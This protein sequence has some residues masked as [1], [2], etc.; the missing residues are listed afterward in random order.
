MLKRSRAV[1]ARRPLVV[2][3]GLLALVLFGRPAAGQTLPTGF[4]ESIVFSGLTE[5]TALQFAPD[6]RVF[7]A[8]KSGLVKVFDG[9]SDTTATVF[10]DLRT[11]VHNFWDR[12][13]LGLALHPDFPTTPYV[14][15]LYAYDAAIGGTA[16]RWGTVGATSDPCPDPPGATTDGCVVSG[17]LSRLQASGNVMTGSE[18]VLI[19]DWCQQYPSHSMG[20]LAFGAD[21]ALYVSGGDGSSFDFVDYGQDGNPLNP[22]GDPPVGVG[23]VQS[24]P[25]AEGGS[26]RTQSLR[27]VNGPVVLG[28]TILR[29]DP[30]TGAALP[31]NPLADHPDS[32]A[33]RVIAYGLRNPFRFTPRPGTSEIWIGD[34]GW[35]DWEEVNRVLTPTAGVANFGWPCYE[36]VSAQQGYADAG[37]TM[38][39][40]LYNEANAATSPVLTYHHNAKVVPGETCPT[41]SS[42]ITGMA[43][44]DGATYPANYAGALFF[45]DYSRDCIWVMFNPPGPPV[46]TAPGLVAA[47]NFNEGSGTAVADASGN[48]HTGTIS[49]ATW[50]TAGKYG[51]ALSFDGVNDWVTVADSNLL[52]LTTGMT[53]MAWIFPTTHGTGVWRNVLIKERTS[54]EVYNLYSNV[55]SNA[56]TVYTVLSAGPGVPQDVRGTEQLPL[57]TWT[58]LGATYD[59]AVLRLYVNGTQVGSR[60]LSGALL[61]SGEVLRIGGNSVWGE[62][63][64][65]RIDE[66]RIY[67]RALAASEIQADMNTPLPDAPPPPT[68]ATFLAGAAGPVDLKI[69]PGGDLFYVDLDGGTIRRIQFGDANQLPTAVIQA[70]PQSGAPPLTVTFDGTGSSD[71]DGDPLAYSWDLNGDGIFG[72]STAA[73]ATFTYTASGSYTVRLTVTDSPG[74]SN[75]ATV[76]ITVGTRPVATIDTPPATA[77]WKVGDAISFSGHATDAEDGNLP[78]SGLSWSLI[79]HHCPSNCH[80]HPLQNFLGVANGTFPAPDHEYPSHLELR[81]TATDSSGLTDT[82]SV[83]LFPQA[84]ALTF[85]SSPS[86]LQLTVGS[87]SSATPFSRTVIIGSNNS[88]S[89][90]SPQSLG[91]TTYGFTSWSDGGAQS[92][93]FVAG[94]DPATYTATYTALGTSGLV[95]AFSFNEASGTTVVDASG[96]GN[97]GTI[98]GATRTTA[99]KYSNALSFDGINDWVTISNSSSLTITGQLT[100]MAWILPT[101]SS[102]VRDIV[103]KEGS[104]VDIY[105]LYHRN[106]RG[107]PE[108]NVFVGG[109]NRTAEGSTLAANTWVHVAGTY[110]GTMLRFFANGV[111]VASTAVSGPIGSSTGSL[112]IGGNSIWGEFFQG[113]ID[114]VRIYNRAL[115]QAQIQNEMNTPI[116]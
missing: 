50:T 91:G 83:L 42:S 114:E 63:F 19:E 2:A 101:T 14:Y 61:T 18:Q 43:F 36:G 76:V 9:L 11:K 31:D 67:N 70:S 5:P 40:N 92:H 13:L 47:Y 1:D 32:N 112:R 4:Q 49:G 12:G 16:P 65:G 37:L 90:P 54:G 52:D 24:P 55:D 88:V 75:T 84:V 85:Q 79:L 104:N 97:D 81:L 23:G 53:M 3:S 72:D 64:Q 51:K 38:C 39:V 86:G 15:V 58:H 109:A 96:F 22:C 102:G 48:V 73:Q 41:G 99:G 27:R 59:G 108:S 107:R 116:P 105:N 44:Y 56:P 69:G 29:V 33:R 111:E 94:P 71:P 93:N 17:R 60:P 95:A 34:V 6:G 66:V 98:S 82:K 46:A 57:N 7:V 80:T 106:W 62:Y 110:D 10:A 28:G 77:A 74:A 78:A 103:I 8:E 20:A 30:A 21:G 100:L 87:S 25:T 115:S 113:R 68:L 45:A 26:L 35:R 89:A